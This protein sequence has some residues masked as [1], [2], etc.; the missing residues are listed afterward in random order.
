MSLGDWFC[1]N[2]KSGTGGGGWVHL[3]DANSMA[4]SGL[5]VEANWFFS[6]GRLAFLEI[7]IC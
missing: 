5:S 2:R 7:L 6:Y 4:V 3:K 1:V